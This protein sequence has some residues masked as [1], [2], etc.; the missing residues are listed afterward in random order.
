[1]DSFM[2]SFNKHFLST[3]YMPSIIL[4]MEDTVITQK[5][6]LFYWNFFSWWEN[7]TRNKTPSCIWAEFADDGLTFSHA[8]TVVLAQLRARGSTLKGAPS[9]GEGGAGC[10]LAALPELEAGG[11]RSSPWELL[12]SW[13]V[14]LPH[15]MAA[16][17][18]MGISREPGGS[19]WYGDDVH[20][21]Y[22]SWC[23]HQHSH[24]HAQIQG[25]EIETSL[26]DGRSIEE[27]TLN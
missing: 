4:G 23:L 19:V 9:Q 27:R 11:L 12:F 21:L 20:G 2:L 8:A 7:Q 16:E 18:S 1:M 10:W 5:K 15:S 3:Y 13:L 14:E 6:H 25:E 17:S 22:M 24:T 26:L